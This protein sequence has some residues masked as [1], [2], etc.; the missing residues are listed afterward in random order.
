MAAMGCDGPW[1]DHDCY[2]GDWAPT[3]RD[4]VRWLEDYQRDLEQE[5]ADVAA[6]INGLRSRS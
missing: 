1:F 5:A 2:D 3:D 4:Q 6:R